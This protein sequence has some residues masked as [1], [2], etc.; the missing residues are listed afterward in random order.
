[1]PSRDSPSL[2]FDSLSTHSIH[3]R[4]LCSSRSQYGVCAIAL[5]S[6]VDEG[7]RMRAAS[8]A[9]SKRQLDSGLHLDVSSTSSER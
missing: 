7:P 6:S 8:C 4:V 1:M 3:V 2:M 9:S 5:T